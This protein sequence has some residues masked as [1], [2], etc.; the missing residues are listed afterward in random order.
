MG[1]TLLYST[2]T[3]L[4]AGV[5]YRA[6]IRMRRRRILMYRG[7]AEAHTVCRRCGARN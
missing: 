1:T 2:L 4:I 3:L 7:M 6:N 5:I